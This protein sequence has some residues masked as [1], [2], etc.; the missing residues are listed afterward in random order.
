MPDQDKPKSAAGSRPADTFLPPDTMGA[1]KKNPLHMSLDELIEYRKTG[2]KPKLIIDPDTIE[3]MARTGSS[4]QT[5]CGILKVSKNAFYS[6]GAFM[7][8]FN[9]GRAN[10]AHRLRGA[11]V[12]DA[13]D[14]DL[15]QAKLYLDKMLGGDSETVNINATVEAKPLEHV[16]TDSL[17]EVMYREQDP[18][19]PD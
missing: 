1:M 7:T 17:L 18:S 14:K 6:N 5:I 15:L 11:I 10:L 19:K 3:E 9:S 2:V 4:I 8:A 12:E 13:F 16:P